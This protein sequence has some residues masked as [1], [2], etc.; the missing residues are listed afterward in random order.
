LETCP[1]GKCITLVITSSSNIYILNCRNKKRNKLGRVAILVGYREEEFK[2]TLLTK[3]A[4]TNRPTRLHVTP[5][6][7]SCSA[8]NSLPLKLFTCH[9]FVVFLLLIILAT[10]IG[11]MSFLGE[12]G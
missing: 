2:F 11:N 8:V 1:W 3:V 6:A 9:I 12:G 4:I 7:I 5:P 10:S